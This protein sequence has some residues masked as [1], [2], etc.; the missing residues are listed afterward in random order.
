M[1]ETQPIID[2]SLQEANQELAM[3]D[4]M[5]IVHCRFQSSGF[6]EEKV[7][8]WKS[9]YLFADNDP[10][11]LSHLLHCENIS[12]YP[13][14]TDVP[15]GKNYYFTLYFSALPTDCKIFTLH[16]VIPESDG[17]FIPNVSR[18]KSDIYNLT[19]T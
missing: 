4:K 6:F 15:L 19:I 14:W 10:H 3:L 18:N 5:V 13:A 1:T 7:R 11:Q 16:E 12:I 9:T 8:I 17:F 2:P